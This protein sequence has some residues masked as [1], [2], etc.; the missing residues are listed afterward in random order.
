MPG[1]PGPWAVR[2]SARTVARCSTGS[3]GLATSATQAPTCSRE[4]RPRSLSR[5]G[6]GAV[7]I[8][9]LSWRRASAP[10]ATTAARVVCS[11]RRASRWPRWRGLVRWSRAKAS[12]PARMASRG[13]A[14]GAVSAAGPLGPVDLHHPL[15][16]VDQKPGSARPHNTRFL[17]APRPAGRG[18]G[19]RPAEAAGRG[20]PG[21][22]APPGWPGPRRWGPAGP[23]RGGR[24][25]CRPR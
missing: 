3:L 14:L 12:R 18:P 25:G 4:G 6:S 13:V 16:L 21:R 8:R 1:R 15:A 2:A 23:R 11:T 10:A 22:L 9:A 5:S 20:R 24:G 19:R 7:T 17:P